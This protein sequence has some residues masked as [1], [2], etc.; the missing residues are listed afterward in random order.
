MWLWLLT[1]I[2]IERAALAAG[3]ESASATA[4]AGAS[5]A[6]AE[7]GAAPREEAEILWTEAQSL[8]GSS[9]ESEAIPRLKR[10]IARHPASAHHLE[11]HRALGLAY[12]QTGAAAQAVAPLRHFIDGSRKT[13]EI[14]Q[15]K[16]LLGR[17]YLALRRYPELLLLGA[18]IEKTTAGLKPA[19]PALLSEGLL[20][21]TKA[22]HHLKRDGEALLTL[23]SAT[24]SAAEAVPPAPA[25][26]QGDLALTRLDIKLAECAR[27]PSARKMAEEQVRSQMLR[28]GNCLLE[29]LA[30]HARVS[31]ARDQASIDE[32]DRAVVDAWLAYLKAA[33]HPPLPP[34]LRPVDRTGRELKK[35]FDELAQAL[36]REAR[37]KLGEASHLIE[38][39][40]GQALLHR[41]LKDLARSER[42][43]S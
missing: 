43:P 26:L 9:R 27:L 8:M 40:A 41:S 11:A 10:L 38:D 3:H 32:A 1:S 13:T 39:K 36:T 34:P 15:G 16:V 24:R 14:V 42:N 23:D 2:A 5:G 7:L 18:E 19:E 35:Y 4:A 31:T 22:L 25:T 17:A 37:Q 12:L 28:R 20:L 21:K 30:L 33:A 29:S 6:P